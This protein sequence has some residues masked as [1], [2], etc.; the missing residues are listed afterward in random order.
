MIYTCFNFF[1]TI[2]FN[3]SGKTYFIYIK[4]MVSI[5]DTEDIIKNELI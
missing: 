4:W 3:E 1:I 5:V 2:T